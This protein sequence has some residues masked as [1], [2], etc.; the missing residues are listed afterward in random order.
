MLPGQVSAYD[1]L[2][3]HGWL[4]LAGERIESLEPNG[5]FL[6]VVLFEIKADLT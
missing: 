3:G 6:L 4:V 1:S 5:S 2:V